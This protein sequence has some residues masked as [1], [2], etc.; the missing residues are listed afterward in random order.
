MLKLYIENQKN[1][2]KALAFV[3]LKSSRS[4]QTRLQASMDLGSEFPK[5]RPCYGNQGEKEVSPSRLEEVRAE[6]HFQRRAGKE[7]EVEVEA[8][9]KEGSSPEGCGPD[10]G[11]FEEE[12]V[13]EVEEVGGC[14]TGPGSAGRWDFM[15]VIEKIRSGIAPDAGGVKNV[16]P[17]STIE[18]VEQS[19]CRW[20]A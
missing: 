5:N 16:L 1:T 8:R 19:F 17:S 15:K 7:V 14:E 3:F 9:R 12:E 18:L 13:E 11:R 10:G 4:A 2:G 20:E 6:E